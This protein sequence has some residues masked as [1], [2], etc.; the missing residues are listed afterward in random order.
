M[1]LRPVGCV[2]AQ[3]VLK[4]TD[5]IL[6]ILGPELRQ[7]L[8]ELGHVDALVEDLVMFMALLLRDGAQQRQRGF[9]QLGLVHGHVLLGEAPL[10]VHHRLPG[11]AGL[12]EVDDAAALIPGPGQLSLHRNVCLSLFC[13]IVVLG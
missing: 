8:L 1:L 7:P 2:G 11:E 6:S 4:E 12:V 9:V 5:L 10:R 3:L 13:F